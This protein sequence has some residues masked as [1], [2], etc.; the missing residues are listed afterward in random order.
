MTAK[1]RL[2]G[3]QFPQLWIDI[4][5]DTVLSS[6]PENAWQHIAERFRDGSTSSGNRQASILRTTNNGETTMS[7]STGSA[8]F[9][10]MISSGFRFSEDA[11]MS[12]KD[13]KL[14]LSRIKI[15]STLSP[16]DAGNNAAIVRAVAASEG[17]QFAFNG[18]SDKADAVS[19]SVG[20]NHLLGLPLS[21]EDA[22]DAA[23]SRLIRDDTRTR[24]ADYNRHADAVRETRVNESAERQSVAETEE[25][26]VGEDATELTQA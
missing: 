25:S 4:E 12:A 2:A 14:S 3:L 26:H 18:V 13:D 1:R 22:I 23:A 21:E 5:T 19:C 15:G 9:D 11:T 6:I 20:V 8:A 7:R 16:E 17:G 24:T 10:A